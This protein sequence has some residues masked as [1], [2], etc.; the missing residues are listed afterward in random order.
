MNNL[1]TPL[2][3]CFYILIINSF[4]E[5][6]SC[7]NEATISFKPT[8]IS[9]SCKSLTLLYRFISFIKGLLAAK[10]NQEKCSETMKFLLS[11]QNPDGSFMNL[12]ATIYVMQSLVGALPYDVTKIACPENEEGKK[13]N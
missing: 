13:I 7:I 11:R 1:V 4:T 6:R 9:K 3:F 2:A 5:E 8:K 12:G 10:V